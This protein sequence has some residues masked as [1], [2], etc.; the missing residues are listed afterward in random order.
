MLHDQL[1]AQEGIFLEYA[2][3]ESDNAINRTLHHRSLRDRVQASSFAL[4][5]IALFGCLMFFIFNVSAATQALVVAAEQTELRNGP[6]SKHTVLRMLKQHTRLN[7][8]GVSGEWTDVAVHDSG[9]R[10]WVNS[11]LLRTLSVA[12]TALADI[13][14]RDGFRFEGAT[15]IHA[16]TFRFKVPRDTKMHAAHFRLNWRVSP[17]VNELAGLRVDINGVPAATASLSKGEDNHLLVPIQGG[18]WPSGVL[19]ITVRASLPVSKDRCL[20]ERLAT[21][22]LHI[23]PESGIELVYEGQPASVRDAWTLLPPT[24]T[25]SLPDGVMT[26]DIF[27]TAWALTDMLYRTGREVQFV[28][29]P[30]IGDVV[31][32]P[33]S[34]IKAALIARH[35]DYYASETQFPSLPLPTGEENVFLISMPTHTLLALTDPFDAIPA[36]LLQEQWHPLATGEGYRLVGVPFPASNAAPSWP[37]E[38]G[39]YYELPLAAFGFDTGPRFI[40]TR[41]EWT[42]TLPPGR[43]PPMTRPS[44]MDLEVVAPIR[45][46]G[47]GY[48]LYV[49]LNDVLLRAARLNDDGTSQSILVNLPN[50]YHYPSNTVRVV[51]Q[52]DGTS[53]DC[54][55]ELAA[56]PIQITPGSK[57]IVEHD[58][59]LPENFAALSRYL[60]GGFD[61]YMP[62]NYLEHPRALPI[63]ARLSADYQ[64]TVDFRRIQ[65]LDG[66]TPVTPQRPFVAI[67][68]VQIA[69]FKVPVRFDD[70]TVRIID[71]KN[72][73]LLDI[74]TLPGITVAQLLRGDTSHGLWVRPTQPDVLPVLDGLQLSLDDVAFADRTGIVLTIDSQEPSLARI[75]YPDSSD[76]TGILAQYRFWLLAL[77][78]LA[79]SILFVYMYRKTQKH[80]T[81]S[82]AEHLTSH[83]DDRR[84]SS[85]DSG[86]R[87]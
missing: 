45:T 76:W 44:R 81:P 52:H 25:V 71:S 64:L 62:K 65:F 6:G 77:G 8:L 73:P 80:D 54:L 28:P 79:L 37:Q 85:D 67:G 20:D 48:E 78:W 51:I 19:D 41:A 21:S 70:G 66:D 1:H 42:A 10:G 30:E 61:V 60:S 16:Q 47:H 75:H 35:P 55:G 53:G 24:V 14:Y 33:R 2:D 59:R 17:S 4:V 58:E 32:A 63:L 31:L 46:T 86:E 83:F 23:L 11:N 68:D 49:Y 50:H 18:N 9:E 84:H 13:G 26:E 22:F 72:A 39:D 82:K 15:S 38:R 7:A 57:L 74:A 12:T 56:F 34:A 3:V 29:L 69:G 27:A 43:F 87:L 5:Q 40:S 36:Y